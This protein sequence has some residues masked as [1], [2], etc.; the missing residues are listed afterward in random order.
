MEAQ[1]LDY[2]KQPQWLRQNIDN[3]RAL[4]ALEAVKETAYV[5]VYF[6][7]MAEKQVWRGA[8]YR[9]EDAEECAKGLGLMG[10]HIYNIVEV[11]LK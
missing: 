4:P 11:E 1:L 10:K 7:S 5:I 2:S 6:D 8:F 3:Y 9:K